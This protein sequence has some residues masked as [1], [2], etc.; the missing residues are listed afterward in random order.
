ME[1]YLGL[2]PGGKN[3]FGWSICQKDEERLEIIKTGNA[4]H[5]KA[6]LL[7]IKNNLP[8]QSVVVGAG[9]DAP[10]YWVADGSRYSDKLVRKAISKLGSDSSS[11][12]VQQLNSLRGACVIQGPIIAKLL[13]DQFPSIKI[14]ETHPKAL[15]YLLGYVDALCHHGS[16]NIN[17]LN[18]YVNVVTGN[19][20]EHE[21]DSVLGAIASMASVNGYSSW[22]DL[23]KK[24]KDILIPFNYEP[25]YWM[26]WNLVN[27]II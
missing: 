24:E 13:T 3:Q 27:E 6:V 20:S 8:P 19:Y 15:L 10:L 2:D 25:A 12:T 7:A 18:Q 11:G 22:V 23:V 21:R 4:S 1:I 17:D 5:A 9:I 16:I 26:P 14:T